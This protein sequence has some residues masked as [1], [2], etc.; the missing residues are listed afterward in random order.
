MSVAKA[1]PQNP[2]GGSGASWLFH[3]TESLER[4]VCRGRCQSRR[5]LEHYL[6]D[7]MGQLLLS[8]L[9]QDKRD[10]V[11]SLAEASAHLLLSVVDGLVCNPLSRC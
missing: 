4:V 9:P 7:V 8:E 2:Y 5:S 3:H 11:C 10:A 6:Q 1:L